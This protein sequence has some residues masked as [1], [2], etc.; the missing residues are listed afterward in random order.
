MSEFYLCRIRHLNI[1]RA[2]ERFLANVDKL[3]HLPFITDEEIASLYGEQVAESLAV[4]AMYN[5]KEKICQKCDHKC[6]PLVNCELYLPQFSQCPIYPYRPALCRMHFCDHFPVEDISFIREFA[7]I[8]LNSLI[9]A[10]QAGK[11]KVNLFDCP[12]LGKQVPEFVRQ[13]LPLVEAVKTGNFQEAPARDLI[14]AELEKYLGIY[15]GVVE[16]S[17]R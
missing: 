5:Q 9:E 8:F 15:V 7:D 4:L 13:V 11:Q 16:A 12:P 6:C 17:F 2:I 3:E 10:K 14:M 1:D